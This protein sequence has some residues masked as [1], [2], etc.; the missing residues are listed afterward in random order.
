METLKIKNNKKFDRSSFFLASTI[1]I[2]NFWFQALAVGCAHPIS[3]FW[4]KDDGTKQKLQSEV[5][6]NHILPAIP[7]KISNTRTDC[8]FKGN[9]KAFEFELWEPSS[10]FLLRLYFSSFP[11]GWGV[12]SAQGPIKSLVSAFVELVSIWNLPYAR[13]RYIQVIHTWWNTIGGR[14]LGKMRIGILH[15]HITYD[16]YVSDLFSAVTII[17]FS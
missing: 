4:I 1:S 14:N 15:A 10:R 5:Q 17:R 9:R 2:A 11:D 6:T 16:R 8:F 13:H 7:T 12:L 3:S